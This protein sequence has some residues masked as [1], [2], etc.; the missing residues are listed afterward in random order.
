MSKRGDSLQNKGK[1]GS[2]RAASERAASGESKSK[3]SKKTKLQRSGGPSP[4]WKWTKRL[5]IFGVV[6]GLLAALF[7]TFAVGFAA[8]SLPSF[9]QLKS[10]QAGQTILVR[11][12]DGSEIVEIGPSF[13][14]WLE[15]RDIP[16]NN[17]ATR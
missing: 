2:R 14:E 4:L 15:Y 7:L 13:G 5:T 12:R 8:R 16:E 3:S 9:L 1:R 17:E 11:A 10:S 6:S